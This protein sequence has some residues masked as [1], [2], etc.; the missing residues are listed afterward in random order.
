MHIECVY[1]ND[2]PNEIN[3]PKALLPP[4]GTILPHHFK[5]TTRDNLIELAGR[6]CFPYDVEVLTK[7]GW[8]K[9]GE[10]VR[11]KWSD[12]LLTFNLNTKQFEYQAP[13]DYI[14]KEYDDAFVEVNEKSIKLKT[15]KDHN[16]VIKNNDRYELEQAQYLTHKFEISRCAIYPGQEVK[17]F[18]IPSFPYYQKISN[19]YG[20]YGESKIKYTKSVIIEDMN[21]FAEFLG[22]FFSEG[23]VNNINNRNGITIKIYQKEP[24]ASK[25]RECLNKL[26]FNFSEF[27][28]KRQNVIHFTIYCA[29]LGRYLS[30]YGLRS[31]D[32]QLPIEVFDWPLNLREILLDAL[33]FGDG[34]LQN[35]KHRIYT[36]NSKI[37]ADD[38]QRLITTANRTGTICYLEK[39]NI[40]RVRECSTKN[41]YL[42][43]TKDNSLFF[44]NQEDTL[45][46]CVSVPNKTLLVR[47]NNSISICGNCYDSCKLEKTRGTV[48][49]HKHINEVNHGSVQE[50]VNITFEGSFKVIDVN[51]L[52][53]LLLHLLNRPGIYVE[54][55]IPEQCTKGINDYTKVRITA[56]VRA[57]REWKQHTRI[58][59]N[60]LGYRLVE[61]AKPL[62]PLAIDKFP[63][64]CEDWY[65]FNW[66]VILPESDEEI[67]VS[68]YINGVSRGLTHELVRHKFRTAVSQ[69]STR[70]VDESESE[71]SWHPLLRKYEK[72]LMQKYL[73]PD[74]DK[75]RND[76]D[77]L[78][79]VPK[80]DYKTIVDFLQFKLEQE[81][82]DKFTARKQSRGAARGVLG[83]A[84]STELIFSASLAQWKRI[85]LQR[86]NDAADAEIR[87]MVTDIYKDLLEKY[88]DRFT[89]F[90]SRPSKDGFGLHVE[91]K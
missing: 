1:R 21:S 63:T 30:L 88:P 54:T 7:A 34:T 66:T 5:S 78:N 10:Y 13:T 50:H 47:Y 79:I 73:G 15:T 62:C 23:C 16:W 37:L 53:P 52:L 48:D 84:L 22:Y 4:D 57:L 74:A 28:D 75:V 55:N 31:C 24:K 86:C 9:I 14:C 81:G 44:S 40:Y 65:N 89:P 26:Q 42:N 8:V 39:D 46:Y 83:N 35:N 32:K 49:Y 76:I 61:L 80:C 77:L 33:M 70:Y 20:S 90:V 6:T 25:I 67:W 18:T 38:V 59:E 56:N 17:S 69:R 12:E 58:L 71:W 91:I 82:L 2:K 45:V 11:N 29:E 51:H 36:T 43:T 72:E 41:W 3:F 19:Q 85:I 87:V 27:L 60:N 68:Y 64:K